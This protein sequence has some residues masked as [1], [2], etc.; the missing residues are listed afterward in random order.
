MSQTARRKE[1]RKNRGDS[2]EGDGSTLRRT[3]FRSGAAPGCEPVVRPNWQYFNKALPRSA[4]QLLIVNGI[5]GCWEKAPR[6]GPKS[7]TSG[8]PA[9]RKLLETM[10]NQACS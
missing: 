8:C 5:E 10:D 1:E 9:N 2:E 6:Q 4:P 7:L 3:R